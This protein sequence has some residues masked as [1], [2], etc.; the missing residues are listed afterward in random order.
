MYCTSLQTS[1]DRHC[2]LSCSPVHGAA[3]WPILNNYI[4]ILK[5]LLQPPYPAIL[6]GYS[7][8]SH[9][10]ARHHGVQ[11]P[12]R[13]SASVPRT[14]IVPISHRCRI[15]ASQICHPTAPGRTT[16]PTQLVWP[17]GFLCG[18]SVGLEFP[19]ELPCR[20]GLLVGTVS[21]NLWRRFCLQR[22]DAFSALEVSRRCAI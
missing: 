7:W 15:I 2:K 18:W 19:A 12:P 14:L 22:T 6:A 8:A 13:S 9:V 5:V 20:I 11:L 21:D 1:V 16:P 3:T 4:S 17:M 10:Q